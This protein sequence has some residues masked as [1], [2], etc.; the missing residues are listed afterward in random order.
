VGRVT[1]MMG[2]KRIAA[3]KLEV[4]SSFSINQLIN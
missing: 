4:T 2:A 1:H 3:A